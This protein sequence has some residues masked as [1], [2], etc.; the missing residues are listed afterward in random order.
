LLTRFLASNTD[1]EW[2]FT[3]QDYRGS[4]D[5]KK[6]V[7]SRPV[8]PRSFASLAHPKSPLNSASDTR[9]KAS[10]E[11]NASKIVDLYAEFYNRSHAL[12]ATDGCPRSVFYVLLS[13]LPVNAP[14]ARLATAIKITAV[15]NSLFV[16]V[17]RAERRSPSLE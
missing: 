9:G 5:L 8:T 17:C 14:A 15:S 6:G 3:D 13:P 16:T 1:F 11:N 12:L 10:H 7:A 2:I 4:L